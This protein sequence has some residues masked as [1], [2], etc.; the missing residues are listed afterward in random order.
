MHFFIRLKNLALAGYGNHELFPELMIKLKSQNMPNQVGHIN[1]LV[2]L[3]MNPFQKGKHWLHANLKIYNVCKTI[4]IKKKL[5]HFISMNLNQ[6]FPHLY[7]F[8]TH[9]MT[10]PPVKLPRSGMGY[11][12]VKWKRCAQSF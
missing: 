10:M 12:P 1:S 9:Y 11:D 6:Y 7:S 5:G 8:L 2:N 4:K 3:G